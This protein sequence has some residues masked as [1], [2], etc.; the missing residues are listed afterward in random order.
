MKKIIQYLTLLIIFPLFFLF[1][2]C[3]EEEP[4]PSENAFNLGIDKFL[5]LP[6]DPTTKDQVKMVTHDCKYNELASVK[7][8]GKDIEVK[9]RFNSMMKWPCIL[10]FD[11]IQLGQLKQ[12]T[13]E[14]AFLIVD[15]NPNV[16]DSVSVQ[17]TVRLQVKK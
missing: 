5:I 2:F 14:V 13:Y 17:E 7:V 3:H 16:I 8:K 4:L 1:Q 9:K 6:A 10:A 15:T 11:T 12:G